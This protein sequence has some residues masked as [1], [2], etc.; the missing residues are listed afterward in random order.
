MRSS[1]HH[2]DA[3]LYRLM[4]F[5]EGTYAYLALAR[6]AKLADERLERGRLL[7]ELTRLKGTRAPT[8]LPPG[9]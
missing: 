3:V 4:H 1:F 5:L 6:D 2:G 7:G 9:H 8:L